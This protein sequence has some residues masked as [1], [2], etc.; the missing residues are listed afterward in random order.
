MC[1][2]FSFTSL[3][4]LSSGASLETLPK[5]V[6]LSKTGLFEVDL[7]NP[8]VWNNL[9]VGSSG[10]FCRVLGEL[11]FCDFDR[12]GEIVFCYSK[13]NKKL[14]Y[15]QCKKLLS[16]KVPAWLVLIFVEAS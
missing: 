5:F 3:I 10:N 2:G 4:D 6:L 7:L 12:I 13:L 11:T 15:L 9:P 1:F 14:R 8:G 16:I